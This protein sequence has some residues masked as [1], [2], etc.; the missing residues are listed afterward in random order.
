M[1][2]TMIAGLLLVVM[3]L[4]YAARPDARRLNVIRSLG[5]LTLLVASLGFVAG[6]IKSF[7]SIPDGEAVGHWAVHGVGESLSNIG[8]AL[9]SLAIA[10]IA[11]TIGA[12]RTAAPARA[13]LVDPMA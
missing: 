12:A 8:A 6:V 2:P 5:A 4:L 11:Q 13:D 1:Y 3:S 7:T 10:R 9:T